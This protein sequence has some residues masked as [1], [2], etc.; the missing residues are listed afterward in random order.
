MRLPESLLLLLLTHFNTAG[1]LPETT[2]GIKIPA[3][4][5]DDL[6]VFLRMDMVERENLPL[7][8][9]L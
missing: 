8:V 2:Q 4:W 7:Q 9:V 1:K 5:P 3:A 6:S